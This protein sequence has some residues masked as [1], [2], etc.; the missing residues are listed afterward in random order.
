[1]LPMTHDMY[2]AIVG[3]GGV[4]RG[5]EKEK[6]GVV[7]HETRKRLFFSNFGFNFVDVK[8]M[9]SILIYK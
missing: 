6:S 9:K 7:G 5:G 1:M 4:T 3:D 2:Y 8:G